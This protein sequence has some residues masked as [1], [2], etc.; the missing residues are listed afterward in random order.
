[1]RNST[2]LTPTSGDYLRRLQQ[3]RKTNE[4]LCRKDGKPGEAGRQ[5][6]AYNRA[7]RRYDLF[8]SSRRLRDMEAPPKPQ[9]LAS[10]TAAEDWLWAQCNSRVC[11]GSRPHV[12]LDDG[13][14]IECVYCMTRRDRRDR[15]VR[16]HERKPSKAEQ[17]SWPKAGSGG[18]G[19]RLRG[20]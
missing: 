3:V 18:I 2:T 10:S 11:R 1:M 17:Q 4:I 15:A 14:G 20:I 13:I 6:I 16:P 5:A 8:Y 12:I 7:M 9:P 19:D